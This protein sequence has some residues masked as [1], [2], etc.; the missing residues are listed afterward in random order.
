M[1][2]SHWSWGATH[3]PTLK[4]FLNLHVLP[5]LNFHPLTFHHNPSKAST[6]TEHKMATGKETNA[7]ADFTSFY[8]QQ[9]TKEFAE[10]LDK[11]RTA[12]D[13]KGDALPILIKAL[14]QG[15]ALFSAG[16]QQRIMDAGKKVADGESQDEKSSS[17]SGSEAEQ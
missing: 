1:F 15:T 2:L 7:S 4:T 10:D 8:L 16:D 11:V 6:S 5:A 17:G 9:A 12:D 14:Q 3:G 13:F